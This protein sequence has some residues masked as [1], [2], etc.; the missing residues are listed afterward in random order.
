MPYAGVD[1]VDLA[2]MLGSGY[3]MDKPT[4]LACLDAM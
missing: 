1:P 4:N 2:H 3:R